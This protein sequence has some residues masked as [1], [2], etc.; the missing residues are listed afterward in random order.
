MPL[1]TLDTA[2]TAQILTSQA[3]VITPRQIQFALKFD[4]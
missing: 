2:T 4:F 3:P 1:T